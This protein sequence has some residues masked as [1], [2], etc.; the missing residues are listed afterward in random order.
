MTGHVVIGTGHVGL[1]DIAH[2]SK[3]RT[4]GPREASEQ[5]TTKHDEIVSLLE[6]I[7]DNVEALHVRVDESESS[8]MEM[9]GSLS[10]DLR[11]I[12]KRA[13]IKKKPVTQSI[14]TIVDI[15]DLVKDED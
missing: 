3:S 6:E 13:D 7:R 8:M 2:G 15:D 14:P 11:K 4:Q 5:M 12:I 1:G 9:T 10:A